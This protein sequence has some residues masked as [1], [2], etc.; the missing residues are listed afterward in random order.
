MG[1]ENSGITEVGGVGQPQLTLGRPWAS[2]WLP[3]ICHGRFSVNKRIFVVGFGLYGS[4]HG[5]TDYQVNIQ[6]I[7][8]DSN[9]VLGQND[10]GFSCD[11]S[12][13]TFRVMFKEPVEVLPNVNYT[14]CATLKGP[15]SHYGTKGL[16]KVTHESPTTGAKTCFTFCYAAGN[17]NGTSVE[18]GQIPEVIFYT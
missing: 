4:I 5:P 9:T 14:A 8:T 3:V 12:A 11:G 15:D 7:H 10:T 17:N 1:V 18:D 2:T 16:R 6:I 13:S